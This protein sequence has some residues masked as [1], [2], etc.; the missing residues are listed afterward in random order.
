MERISF[1]KSKP[2]LALSATNLLESHSWLAY[3]ETY[4][5]T[6]EKRKTGN[7]RC[8]EYTSSNFFS[9]L[10]LQYLDY[11]SRKTRTVLSKKIHFVLDSN[12]K[13]DR[14]LP[15]YFTTEVNRV[16][17]CVL[18]FSRNIK[19]IDI[20]T[21]RVSTYRRSSRTQI[22]AKNMSNLQQTCCFLARSYGS[23]KSSM[24]EKNNVT[25]THDRK[26]KL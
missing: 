21:Y 6:N 25:D 22:S 26:Q 14:I 3:L 24:T 5:C 11:M 12:S 9:L 15:W 2:S 4:Y 16:C 13:N 10:L 7:V 20:E 8:R 19:C 23:I 1:A 18:L 17:V